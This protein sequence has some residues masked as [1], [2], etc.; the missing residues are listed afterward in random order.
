MIHGESSDNAAAFTST[1]NNLSSRIR[2]QAQE[3]WSATSWS[4]ESAGVNEQTTDISSIISE[5]TS[6]PGWE[7]GNALVLLIEGTGTRS[8][9]SRDTD[10][11]KSAKLHVNYIY[12]TQ[13]NTS[14]I[15]EPEIVIYPN[16]A[17]DIVNIDLKSQESYNLQVF[18]LE[19]KLILTK[20]ALKGKTTINISE[21]NLSKGVY[22]FK[23]NNTSQK[24]IIQ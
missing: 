16:P 4:N 24:V 13:L 14:D 12:E 23:I 11:S 19:G 22:I 2:T 8:A 10:A 5:I 21:S 6:R 3:L 7:M 9:Y 20:T 1:D 15:N 17:Q 18:N